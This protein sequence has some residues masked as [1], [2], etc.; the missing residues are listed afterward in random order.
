MKVLVVG[1]GGR[2]HALAWKLL[3]S[4]RV[5]R[6]WCV[7]GNGGTALLERCE[8]IPLAVEDIDG[9][10]QVA[11]KNQ[12]DLVIVGPEVPLSLGIGDLLQKKGIP[13]FGPTRLGA[14]IESSKSWAKTLM[15][16][17][18]VPVAQGKT[19]TNATA[20]KA[21]INQQGTPIVVK[22]DGLAAGKG[23][24]VTQTIPEA[25]AAVDDLFK[26][27]FFRI[28]VEECLIG[29]EV[30]ILAITD[31]ITV[32][33]LLP[34]QDHKRIGEGDIGLNTGGMGAYCPAPIATPDL[35]Q[36]VDEEILKPTVAALRDRGIDYRGVLYAGLMVSPQGE[37]KVL[38][39]NCRFGD[40]ETQAVL[41]LLE[42]PLDQVILACVQQ[43]LEE[44]P[45]LR[46]HLGTA[47]CV[48]AVSAGY[49]GKY[50]KGKLITGIQEAEAMGV[51]VFQAGTAL[52][53]D[54]LVTDGGRV[55]GVTAIRQNLSEAIIEVYKGVNS[56]DFEGKYYRRDIGYRARSRKG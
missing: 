7:P 31:G 51:T 53:G 9:I 6:C 20:A 56:I 42:T 23:V 24:I 21:Y 25:Y 28:L 19:F 35:L 37:L 45:P 40:P 55:L 1:D 33:S 5:Q 2:E 49:P 32:R 36:R 50:E 26:M 22:A 10:A 39:Y 38:E 44:L 43:R 54:R 12:I 17:A 11:F 16:E 15:L 41:P 8:N 13:V 29:E 18:G 47:V 46:W 27:G 4:L 14:K 48:V 34:A 3:Q 52:E 30:S